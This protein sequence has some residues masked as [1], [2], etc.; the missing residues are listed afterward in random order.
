MIFALALATTSL[1]SLAPRSAEAFCGFYVAG[2]DAK[3]F[4][5]A[6]V[7]VLMRDGT[8][9]VVSMRNAYQG[10]PESFALIIPVP[11]VLQEGDVQTLRPELFDRV[12]TLASPRLVEYWEQDPCTP[13]LGDVVGTIGTGSGAGFGGRGGGGGSTVTIE[14][15]FVV[16]EYEIVILSATE[17]TGLDAWLREHDY[18]IPAGAEPLLRPYVQQDMKFFVAKVDPTKVKFD[19]D[20]R[21]MLSPLRFHYD[22]KD[23]TLPVRLGLIN[24][25]D[26]ASGGKQDL[27]IH[28]LAPGTRYEASN[29]P[30]VT[31]PTNLDVTDATRDRFGEFYVSLFDHT[32]A[33]HPG[34]LVTEYAWAA[35]SCDPCPGPEAA[36]TNKELLELGG[37][38]L[39]NWS[40]ALSTGS[41]GAPSIAMNTP[42]V[43]AG[44]QRDIVRRIVRAHINELRHCYNLG[45]AKNPTLAGT[46]DLDF[47]IDTAGKV[48][49]VSVDAEAT[50][51]GDPAVGACAAKAVRR[52]S[53]PKSSAPVVVSYPFA[54]SPTGGGGGS[55][56]AAAS[57]VLTRLH[58]RYDQSSLGEDLVFEAAPAIVGGREMLGKDGKLEQGALPVE[59]GPSNFQARYAIRH[60]W[61]GALACEAPVRGVWGAAPE[62][63]QAPVIARELAGASRGASL[64]SFLTGGSA[65]FG[66]VA[67]PEAKPASEP[68]AAPQPEAKPT[69]EPEASAPAP[70]SG[71]GCTSEPG[72]AGLGLLAL[73]LLALVRRRS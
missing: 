69:S 41:G 42:T 20:G 16:A 10:P 6:T 3:L 54:L 27:L 1:A 7:V 44:L 70:A 64:A 30:N 25:P 62:G 12:D 51:L 37:D 49:V 52:W 61:A 60:A 72:P 31:I 66:A 8:R 50:T 63:Q 19:A 21:A 58:A 24:A 34:A 4:N 5:D 53:F 15:Q 26:P 32:L 56:G 57:F 17:S 55:S 45:L 38:V 9:T 46:L 2:A 11:T 18:A 22:S 71:C 48:S 28:I 29:Y 14:A 23:F 33:Q 40:S 43:G 73:G 68:A 36:L 47:T 65:A 13:G 67:Q 59:Y 35:G 39:P